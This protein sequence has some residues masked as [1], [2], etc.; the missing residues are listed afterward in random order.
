MKKIIFLLIFMMTLPM[1]ADVDVTVKPDPLPEK[2]FPFPEF[3]KVKLSNGIN[4]IVINDKEQPTIALN[5][6]IPGGS[7]VDGKHPGLASIVAELMTKGTESYSALDFARTLDGIGADIRISASGDYISVYAAGL[8][9]HQDTLIKLVKEAILSPIF[10]EDE[11]EKVISNM[12]SE[13]VAEKGESSTLASYLTKKVI[14]GKDHPYA[15]RPTEKSLTK[16]ELDDVKEYFNQYFIPNT[17]SIAILGDI[18]KKEA[19]NLLEGTF[20]EWKQKK[21]IK[22]QVPDAHPMYRGVYFIHREGSAQASVQLSTVGLPVDDI[23][24]D[25]MDIAASLIGGGFAS[26]LF[27]TLREEHSYT[28]SPYG[29]LTSSKYVNRFTCGSDVRSDV[30]DS[31]IMVIKAQLADLASTPPADDE[32]NRIKKYNVGSYLMN[33]E[34]SRFVARLIQNGLFNGVSI[35]K[36]KSYPERVN[37]M[38]GR[39]ISM[40]TR[41]HMNPNNSYIVVVGDPS[42]RESLKQFG[43]VYDYDTDLNPLPEGGKLTEVSID[44]EDLLENYTK[45]IGGED[46]LEDIG[47]IV[48]NGSH[49]LKGGSMSYD[50]TFEQIRQS[51]NMLYEKID[52]GMIQMKKWCNGEKAWKNS[53]GNIEELDGDNLKEEKLKAQMFQTSRMIELGYKAKVQGSADGMILLKVTSPMGKEA[54]YYFDE[55]TFLLKRTYRVFQAAGQTFFNEVMFEDYKAVSGVMFPHKKIFKN[56]Q[57]VTEQN[58]NYSVNSDIDE[59]VFSPEGK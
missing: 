48:V 41:K 42:I 5:I 33:F 46:A 17:A 36:L 19:I 31:S 59:D 15:Q 25:G 11:F 20:K 1:I 12:Q 4:L 14:Y 37:R 45:A 52:A 57:F 16:I 32:L 43:V 24:Y 7:S 10:D 35:A 58:L 9:K 56:S 21:A 26:R 28:Y 27:K 55:K 6:L 38:D 49:S 13:I 23:D 34:N 22:I 54:T 39:Y 53:Q 30:T 8:R 44:A 50:G 40:M 51:P 47:N 29:Y 18:K 2:S 3:E